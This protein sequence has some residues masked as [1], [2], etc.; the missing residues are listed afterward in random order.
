MIYLIMDKLQWAFDLAYGLLPR[1]LSRNAVEPLLVGHRGVYEHPETLENTIAAFDLAIAHGGGIEFDL[2]LTR[3]SVVVVHHDPTLW[4]VHK[5]P[6]AVRDLTLSQLQEIAPAV[7]TLDEVLERYGHSCPHYFME[8]KVKDQ[9]SMETLVQ[10]VGASL[11]RARLGGSATL[12]STDTR[13]LDTARRLTPWMAKAMVFFV[14]HRASAAYVK[15]HGDTGLAGWY[16][17]FPTSLRP[18]LEQRGLHIGVGQIDYGNTYR[19]FRN[20]G[21]RYHFTN[22]IDR[23]VKPV[24]PLT[25]P[26]PARSLVGAAG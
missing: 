3:D 5:A 7:P 21:F 15:K 11:E 13:M 26:V 4:R 25:L 23:L 9:R 12:I 1:E 19:H 18:F 8:P 22:R 2:H 10:S 6:H 24:E 20:R 17:T 16:F 14:D